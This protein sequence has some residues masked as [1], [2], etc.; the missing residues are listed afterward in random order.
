METL[1]KCFNQK[2]LL[3]LAVLPIV[4]AVF[5]PKLIVVGILPLLLLAA[6]PISMVIMVFMLSK[7][8]GV[9]NDKKK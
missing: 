4:V 3:G 5:A 7:S 1:K 6:C 9:D 8:N 2:V